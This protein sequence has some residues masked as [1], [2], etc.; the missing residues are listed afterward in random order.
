MDYLWY[1]NVGY[2]AYIN[3]FAIVSDLPM[4]SVP[5]DGVA[6]RDGGEVIHQIF[7]REKEFMGKFVG[8]G[9]DRLTIE[10]YAAILSKHLA[11]KKFV[12]GKVSAK[13]NQILSIRFFSK[14][15]WNQFKKL[16]IF[17]YHSKYQVV[18]A[19]NEYCTV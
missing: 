13:T 16:I 5:M 15:I 17:L 8:I 1:T 6:V 19:R 14:F 11:P 3:N 9:G 12:D 7:V 18:N 4:G 2:H 10:Q